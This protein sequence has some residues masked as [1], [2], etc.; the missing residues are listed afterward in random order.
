M[1]KPDAYI[2]TQGNVVLVSSRVIITSG[3][4]VS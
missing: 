3:G 1:A 4:N 2:L